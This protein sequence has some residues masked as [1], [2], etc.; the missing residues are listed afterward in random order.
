MT[1]VIFDDKCACPL[2]V[3]SCCCIYLVKGTYGLTIC[4]CCLGLLPGAPALNIEP[5]G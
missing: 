4:V 1:M 5:G 2:S 3:K